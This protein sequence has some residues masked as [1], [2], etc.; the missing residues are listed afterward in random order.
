MV[1]TR[2]KWRKCDKVGGSGNSSNSYD[3][4]SNDSDPRGQ[5]TSSDYVHP[6]PQQNSKAASFG[7]L[8]MSSSGSIAYAN[9][10]V[11]HHPH[12]HPHV[13]YHHAHHSH[14]PPPQPGAYF[15]GSGS[16]SN[17]LNTNSITINSNR[18]NDLTDFNFTYPQFLLNPAN[19]V[20]HVSSMNTIGANST[21]NSTTTKSPISLSSIMASSGITS[22]VPPNT[23][24]KDSSPEL[25]MPSTVVGPN[26]NEDEEIN[27]VDDVSTTSDNM[28]KDNSNDSENEVEFIGENMSTVDCDDATNGNKSTIFLRKRGVAEEEKMNV[29][30]KKHLIDQ[31][32]NNGSYANSA[33]VTNQRPRLCHQSQ[34]LAI[35]TSLTPSASVAAQPRLPPSPKPP[36]NQLGFPLQYQHRALI[37][38]LYSTCKHPLLL[39][40]PHRNTNIPFN[41]L[42]LNKRTTQ[43]NYDEVKSETANHLDWTRQSQTHKQTNDHRLNK[44]DDIENNCDMDVIHVGKDTVKMFYA[45]LANYQTSNCS[46]QQ[47]DQHET[48]YLTEQCGGD[49]KPKDVDNGTTRVVSTV[50]SANL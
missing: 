42:A 10:H 46:E 9:P 8:V 19:V 32:V 37:A 28:P 15:Y 2:A 24:H 30:N 44:E 34:L 40:T 12:Q 33:T 45:N 6:Q 21:T 11:H 27:V 35:L 4:G 17:G 3:N 26:G 20:T 13:T 16:Q 48:Y 1:L 49:V 23:D 18:F 14:Q 41:H 38:S 50:K 43:T 29:P 36:V 5:T 31:S 47:R 25:P 39:P 7:G 22:S